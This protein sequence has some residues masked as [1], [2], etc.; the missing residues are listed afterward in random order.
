MLMRFA[1]HCN[2]YQAFTRTTAQTH[3]ESLLYCTLGLADEAIEFYTCDGEPSERL[4]EL[5]D[6][7][8]YLARL[9]DE[10]HIPLAEPASIAL[11][12]F[13]AAQDAPAGHDAAL[14]FAA[15]KIAGLGKKRLRGDAALQSKTDFVAALL[16][17]AQC[18]L[19]AAIGYAWQYAEG[20]QSA[21]D[22]WLAQ[23]AANQAKLSDRKARGVIQ[24]SG[25]KR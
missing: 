2:A 12:A 19:Q 6:V 8:W 10:L 4:A 7:M 1:E 17:Q 22:K 21:A 9:L 18:L 16:P 24:G 25:D 20:G 14:L 11:A 3:D 5:G 13:E 15:G 23:L